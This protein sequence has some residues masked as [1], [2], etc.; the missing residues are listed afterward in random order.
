MSNTD[1]SWDLLDC[2]LR[3]GGYYTKWDFDPDFVSQYIE[4]M[5][6]AKVKYIE[7]GY[8][9]PP[10]EAYFGEYFFLTTPTLSRISKLLEAG[11]VKYS[12]VPQVAIML[13]AKRCT[14]KLVPSLL[15]GCSDIVKIV[16][17]AVAPN[18]L[19]HAVELAKVIKREGYDVAVNLMYISRHISDMNL[20][21]LVEKNR[22]FVDILNLVDSYGSSSPKQIGDCMKMWRERFPRGSGIILGYHGHNNLSLAF[23]NALT[24]IENGAEIIDATVTGMGRGAGNLQTEIALVHREFRDW[25]VMGIVVEELERMQASFGWGVKLPY[26]L[27][28]K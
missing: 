4:G 12:H 9:S 27:S 17:M 20:L 3:D 26:I 23:A 19:D 18:D 16:R 2:T 22:D 28:G 7:I 8:R 14:P 15:K 13:D 6:A 11:R 24:A 25:S 10:Q 5:C 1:L 21:D